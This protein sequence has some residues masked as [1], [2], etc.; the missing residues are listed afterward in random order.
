LP[1]T[2]LYKHEPEMFV[3]V[4]GLRQ[5]DCFRGAN[6]IATVRFIKNH[7]PRDRDI[8]RLRMQSARSGA[9]GLLTITAS[10]QL[11]VFQS[12]MGAF[13]PTAAADIKKGDRVRARDNEFVDVLFVEHVVMYTDVIEVEFE[14]RHSTILVSDPAGDSAGLFFVEV[15]GELAPPST[16]S[17]VKLL[18]F[19]RFTCFDEALGSAGMLG[20]IR[21]KMIRDGHSPDL[22]DY[23][24]GAL[25]PGKMFV[26]SHVAQAVLFTLRQ[27]AKPTLA[28]EVV[29]SKAFEAAVLDAV[30]HIPGARPNKLCE[31]Q[32]IDLTRQMHLWM[33]TDAFNFHLCDEVIIVERSFLQI[34]PAPPVGARSAVT[35]SS[36][37]ARR[38]TRNPRVLAER[39]AWA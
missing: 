8:V 2:V 15:Y 4:D 34:S 27:R 35:V 11:P 12:S 25:G 14:N 5:G 26:D 6:D 13:R 31:E 24:G 22:R 17:Y 18:K 9:A 1:L 21:Q 23:D 33:N 7:G 38:P 30:L 19:R 29:V 3:P 16:D 10:Q 37:D 36:T 39:V 20:A 28:T 32:A